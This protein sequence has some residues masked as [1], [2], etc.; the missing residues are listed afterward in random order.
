[1]ATYNPA[2]KLA[3]KVHELEYRNDGT[4]PWK[5]TIYQPE[6]SGPFPALLDVHGGAWNRGDRSADEVMNRALA[7]SGI[8][9]AAVDFRLAPAHP[10][11]GAGTGR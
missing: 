8:V 10:V 11:P 2:Q 9:V 1:M 3:V 6:G 4:Q 7:A 5:A